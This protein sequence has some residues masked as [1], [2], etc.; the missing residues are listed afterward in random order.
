METVERKD[1]C[2]QLLIAER[3]AV[4]I[5]YDH[6]WRMHSKL[7]FTALYLKSAADRYPMTWW[8]GNSI[9]ENTAYPRMKELVNP[10]EEADLGAIES[11]FQKWSFYKGKTIPKTKYAE[12]YKEIRNLRD[13]YENIYKEN[14]EISQTYCNFGSDISFNFLKSSHIKEQEAIEITM[15]V[16]QL[17]F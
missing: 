17:E 13:I 10:S 1:L 3:V 8:L 9:T 7:E 14:P 15:G 16:K 6:R 2:V 12:F 11:F 5:R 4:E